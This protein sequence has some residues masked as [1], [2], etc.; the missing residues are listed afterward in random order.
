MMERKKKTVTIILACVS[1]IAA[2]TLAALVGMYFG[3]NEI[4]IRYKAILHNAGT[5]TPQEYT[6]D[7]YDIFEGHLKNMANDEGEIAPYDY[8]VDNAVF[9]GTIANCARF[10]YE[11]SKEFENQFKEEVASCV[12]D[13]GLDVESVHLT[14]NGAYVVFSSNRTYS[15]MCDVIDVLRKQDQFPYFALIVK[16]SLERYAPYDSFWKLMTSAK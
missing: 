5:A 7:G 10:N 14:D 6:I 15:E 16:H 12:K 11:I 8:Y 3:A 13:A 2:L 9:I 1:A 4:Y